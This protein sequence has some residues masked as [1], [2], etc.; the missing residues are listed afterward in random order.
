MK[1][2]VAYGVIALLLALL[3]AGGAGLRWVT[4]TPEGARWLLAAVSRLTP[5][6]ITA[7]EV[8][9]K[10]GSDLRLEG[11]RIAWKDG[12]MEAGT[13]RLRWQWLLLLSGEVAV[14]EL[15]L[16]GVRVQDN[17]PPSPLPPDLGWPRVGGLAARLDGWVDRLRIER[18]S[19]RRLTEPPV[20]VTRLAASLAWHDRF[21]T[22]ARAA[23]DT[24]GGSA[25]GSV[26]AGFERPA[27]RL[28]LAAVPARP[29]SGFDRFALRAR[30]LPG[31]APEQA[32]GKVA[33]TATAGRSRHLELTGEAGVTRTSFNLRNLRLSERGRKGTVTGNASVTLTAGKPLV[34][35]TVRLAGVDLA[36]EL[37]RPTDLSGTLAVA[38]STADYRGRFSLAN[39][40]AGWR[41]GSLSGS[42]RGDGARLSLAPLSGALLGGTVGGELRLGWRGG[43]TLAGTLRGD[44]L[45]PARITP[46]W[47]GVVNL[48]L[49]GTA[50]WGGEP[51]PQAELALRLRE[52]RL[53]GQP[54]TGE[55]QARLSGENLLVDRLLLHGNGFDL[56]ASGE[57]RQRLAVAAEVTDLS[58]LVPET[59]GVLTA[60]GWVRYRDH[61]LSGSLKGRGR[62]LAGFGVAA[63]GVELS[64]SLG[65]AENA[66][67]DLRAALRTVSYDGVRLD[68]ATVE[69]SGTRGRHTVAATLQGESIE[70]A[71][72]LSGGYRAGRW[73]GKITRLAGRDGVGPWRL[74]APAP[75]RISADT[76]SL[77]PLVLA[78]IG[79]ERLEAAAELARKPLRGFA[80]LSWRELELARANRWWKEGRLA[81]GCSG[82]L[83]AELPGGERLDLAGNAALS[84]GRVRWGAA[85]READAAIKTAELSWHWEGSVARGAPE[86]GGLTVRGTVDAAGAVTAEGERLAFTELALQVEGSERGSRARLDL[87]LAGGGGMAARFS[88]P[89]PLALAL[90]DEGSFSGSWQGVDLALAAPWLPPELDLRGR[91]SGEAS[92][93][94]LSGSRFEARGKGGV[95]GGVVQWHREKRRFSATLRTAEA[96]W[97]W[98]GETLDGAFSLAL[99][100][101][102]EARGSF[103]L[104]LAASIPVAPRPDGALR[105]TLA[106]EVREQGLVTSLFPGLVQESHG[107]LG[108]D[109]TVAGTW[110]APKLAGNVKLAKA[111]AYL[112]AAGI[113]LEDLQASARLEGDRLRIDSFSVRS[114]PGALSGT[115]SLR[116]QGWRPAEY[117]GTVAGDRFQAVYLPELQMEASP[118]LTFE[119]T[120]EKV[121]VRGEI[122]VPV[123]L[124]REP[125]SEAPV[126]PS[127]D[128]V[129]EGEK[130]PA[131]KQWPVALD[132]RVRVALG[133]R[134]LVKAQGIDARLGG[135]LDLT[136]LRPDEVRSTGEIRVVKGYYKTY[137]V[138][139]EIVRGRVFY[140]GGPI[141][142]PTLD[143]LAL[144]KVGEVRA[145]VTVG[146]T[147]QT[148]VIKLYSEP[149]MPDTDI[150]AYIVLG[151]PLG[152]S[153]QDASLVM[154]AAGFLLS[155][156]QSV[157]L[158]DQIRQRLGIDVLAITT[159]E[160]GT[161]GYRPVT[162]APPGTPQAQAAPSAI[163]QSMVT[164]GKYLTPE[165][166]LSYGRSLFTNSNLFRLRYS[167]SKHW[168]IETQA[169]TESGADI[170]YKIDFD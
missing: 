14:K 126:R 42:F 3:V 55:A 95:A 7:R 18:L 74:A 120:P 116:L 163:S 30:L 66:P 6:T 96:S 155:A 77:A 64:A 133:D 53:R 63:A 110:R 152:G 51:P 8:A 22:L 111:G 114:G 165:L 87:R 33:L 36:R 31:R 119:G 150:L 25:A 92:G 167:F 2:T 139:L 157:V 98:R 4:G 46:D 54:L 11:M 32:A 154:Q 65:E 118:K 68:A 49:R 136:I 121:A 16:E 158:Q 102:G 146:G 26:V 58:G 27:L 47:N 75:L 113:R 94:L 160:S 128:V 34:T 48:D 69:A 61:R 164:V 44:R 5:L 97:E 166:Y 132:I 101:R 70:L 108:L 15:A 156:S 57:L 67:L 143:F 91:L 90:P 72:T 103:R 50:R 140:A 159:P 1:R 117:R 125:K 28:D 59:R 144:R 105:V 169:G 24:L 23:V 93:R 12:S 19:Y 107:T 10:A 147:P 84:R 168:E 85:G 106:G 82:T 20:T 162:V 130:P 78:G 40:G 17:T 109:L 35:A 21:L 151:H 115:A 161:A 86:G 142:R 89:R 80:R 148:P 71:T 13:L 79:T 100:E 131:G 45:D 122:A 153:S 99:A 73:V 124:V 149:A 129:I 9:G 39:R 112:P 62:D 137:G 134:V 52:S 123:L 43:F 127:P 170:Y 104:P 56:R 60:G 88:S 81:G 83:R 76:F 29:L 41:Q 135:A 138:D 37:G 141:G 38:G 145:G